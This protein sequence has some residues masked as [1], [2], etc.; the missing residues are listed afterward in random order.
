[1]TEERSGTRP[2]VL[3]FPGTKR[4][5]WSLEE[6]LGELEHWGGNIADPTWR[7]RFKEDVLDHLVR[8]GA[9]VEVN[10]LAG[11]KKR[12]DEL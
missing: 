6:R 5:D 2:T 9:R 10:V 4:Q 3:H 12:T 1:M 7:R 11:L 8:Q